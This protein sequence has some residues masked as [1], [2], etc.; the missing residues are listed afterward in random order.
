MCSLAVESGYECVSSLIVKSGYECQLTHC[1]Q[2][3]NVE[4]HS[5]S[6][7]DLD[8]YTLIHCHGRI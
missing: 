1:R 7:Q 3:M 8:M 2:D 4:A 6:R 5:L